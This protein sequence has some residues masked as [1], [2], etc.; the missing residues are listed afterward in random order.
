MVDFDLRFFVLAAHSRP[1]YLLPMY[2]AIALLAGRAIGDRI[3]SFA[4]P[5][6][7]ESI[8]KARLPWWRPKQIVK[9]VAVAS[10]S[11]M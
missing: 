8:D 1:V 3:R 6:D 9:R 2:P 5:S 4:E 10:R 11:L 7:I